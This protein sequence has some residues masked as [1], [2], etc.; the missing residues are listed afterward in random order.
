MNAQS[1]VAYDAD[2]EYRYYDPPRA[3]GLT[4]VVCECGDEQPDM[5][6]E[7]C[8]GC[9]A[10]LCQRCRDDHACEEDTHGND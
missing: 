3:E 1:S 9:D 2:D 4:P 10:V 8:E 6:T 7:R 5:N